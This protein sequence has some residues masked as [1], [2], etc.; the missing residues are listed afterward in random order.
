MLKP[1]R[2]LFQTILILATGLILGAICLI[3]SIGFYVELIMP[4]EISS[5]EVATIITQR[6][7]ITTKELDQLVETKV[8][9][10]PEVEILQNNRSVTRQVIWRILL[11][12]YGIYPYPAILYENLGLP[13][14]TIAEDDLYQPYTDARVAAIICGLANVDDNPEFYMTE[15][16]FYDLIDQLESGVIFPEEY[17]ISLDCVYPRDQIWDIATYSGRKALLV[18]WQKIPTS[19]KQDFLR[20]GWAIGFDILSGPNYEYDKTIVNHP[21]GLISYRDKTIYLEDY[22]FTTPIHEF[23]HY[24]VHRLGWDTQLDDLYNNEASRLTEIL[25]EYSQ[26]SP[27]EYFARYVS[28]H[29]AYPKLS[30]LEMLAP[31]THLLAEQLIQNYDTLLA[32]SEAPP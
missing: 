17:K 22:S 1:L 24:T 5:A 18:C 2:K 7:C 8:L 25:G 28:Y 6:F 15:P 10:E 26:I 32:H 13:F 14:S 12:I 20:S 30:E 21:A 19:W 11:P 27:Q 29:I 9:T 4:K 3:S 16:E 31:N 23:V